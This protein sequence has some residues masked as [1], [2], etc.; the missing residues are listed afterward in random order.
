MKELRFRAWDKNRKVMFEPSS[1]SWKDGALWVCDSHGD[2]KLEYEMVNPDACLM[3]FT[4]LLDKNG[5]EIYEGD[6]IR[7]GRVGDKIWGDC[8]ITQECIGV[9]KYVTPHYDIER[10]QKGI[11]KDQKDEHEFSESRYDGVY[12][13]WGDCEVIGNIHEYPDRWPFCGHRTR[14]GAWL[15]WFLHE[16]WVH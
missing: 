3:Q 14:I 10:I 6:I 7:E 12:E 13:G 15:H 16:L 9:V 8:V 2:N 1:I 11:A 5:K 4:G